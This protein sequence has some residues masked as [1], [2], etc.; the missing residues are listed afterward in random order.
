MGEQESHER[1]GGYVQ[2]LYCPRSGI[3]FI[4]AHHSPF[5]EHSEFDDIDGG[6]RVDG[7]RIFSMEQPNKSGHNAVPEP[8]ANGLLTISKQIVIRIYLRIGS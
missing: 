4:N 1:L 8:I 5:I 6:S 2:A 7:R 3:W